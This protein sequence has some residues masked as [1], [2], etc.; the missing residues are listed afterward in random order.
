VADEKDPLE[1]EVHKGLKTYAYRTYGEY[2]P[3]QNPSGLLKM[4]KLTT[5]A[6][7]GEAGWPDHL[8]LVRSKP[9]PAVIF[10]E[11]KR[12]GGECTEI[13]LDRHAL[14]RGMGF[15]VYVAPGLTRAKQILDQAVA[16]ALGKKRS[17]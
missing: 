1:K 10:I 15:D 5:L 13:Q 4:I 11:L 14:L 12:V 17:A 9:K 7:Y 6:M 2:H 16:K 3:K 8:W